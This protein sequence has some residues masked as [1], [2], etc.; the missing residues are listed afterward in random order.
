MDGGNASCGSRLNYVVL[1]VIPL[2]PKMACGMSSAV[3]DHVQYMCYIPVFTVYQYV[4]VN[5]FAF[6]VSSRNFLNQRNIM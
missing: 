1:L 3:A 5:T 6:S 2:A 4:L